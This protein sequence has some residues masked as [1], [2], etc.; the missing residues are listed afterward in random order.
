MCCR[1]AVVPFADE[2]RKFDAEPKQLVVV[3]K[4][5]R[6]LMEGLIGPVLGRAQRCPSRFRVRCSDPYATTCGR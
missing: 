6:D 3:R 1:F 2:M 4:G 5:L